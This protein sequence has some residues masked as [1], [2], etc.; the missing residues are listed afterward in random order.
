MLRE[1]FKNTPFYSVLRAWREARWTKEDAGREAFYSQFI[2]TQD[3]VFDVGANVGNRTKVFRRLARQVVAIEPQAQCVVALRRKFGGDS[4]VKLVTKAAGAREGPAE[5]LVCDASSISSLS[6]NWVDA[7]EKSG[8]FGGLS[9]DQRQDVETTTLDALIAEFGHPAFIKIDVEGFECEVLCGLSKP[10]RT[11][12][13]EFVPEYLQAAIRCIEH[14]SSLGEARF[15][16]G[17]GEIP[18]LVLGEWVSGE[19]IAAVLAQYA[20]NIAIFGDVYARFGVAN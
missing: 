10:V 19:E 9:W 4:R 1:L 3:L 2:G 18:K 6:R 14:L 17:L 8:R 7:V 20:N 13:F 16:Y 11:L 12:S 5:M 15:N